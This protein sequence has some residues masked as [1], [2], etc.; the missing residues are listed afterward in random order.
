MYKLGRKNNGLEFVPV[1]K[2]ISEVNINFIRFSPIDEYKFVSCGRENIRFW[3]LKSSYLNGCPVVLNHHARQSN[4]TVLDYCFTAESSRQGKERRVVVGAQ[5]GMVYIVDHD[6]RKLQQVLRLHEQA[7]CSLKIGGGF[8]VT[9][10]ADQYI[11]VWP[12]DFGEFYVEAKHD[13][14]VVALDISKDGLSVGLGTTK[15]YLGILDLTRQDCKTVIRAH[16]AGVDGLGIDLPSE[17]L[18]SLG[19]DDT[20]RVWDTDICQQNYEFNYS[21]KDECVCIASLSSS[22]FIGGFASGI[23]RVFDISSVSVVE[24]RCYLKNSVVDLKVS[25]DKRF[26]IVGDSFGIYAIIDIKSGYQL[27]KYIY[28][29]LEAVSGMKVSIAISD[30]SNRIAIIGKNNTEIDLYDTKVFSRVFGFGLNKSKAHS[31][32][33]NKFNPNELIV[34]CVD[35]AVRFYDIGRSEGVRVKY[36]IRKS[37]GPFISS[38]ITITPY[39]YITGGA[40]GLLRVWTIQPGNPALIQI[41]SMEGHLREVIDFILDENSKALFSVGGDEGIFV[42]DIYE[43]FELDE[44]AERLLTSNGEYHGVSSYNSAEDFE[45]EKNEKQREKRILE[46][47]KDV[48]ELN[49]TEEKI[50]NTDKEEKEVV[51]VLKEGIENKKTED[52][53]VV[54]LTDDDPDT[55]RIEYKRIVDTEERKETKPYNYQPEFLRRK[56][57]LSFVHFLPDNDITPSFDFTS[58]NNQQKASLKF[59]NSI[60]TRSSNNFHFN[61]ETNQLFYFTENKLIIENL[62]ET[63]EQKIIHINERISCML[64]SKKLNFVILGCFNT[65]EDFQSPIYIIDLHTHS[66]KKRQLHRKGIQ[67]IALSPDGEYLL[68]IGTYNDKGLYIVRLSDLEIFYKETL[69]RTANDCKI[70]YNKFLQMYV[71]FVLATDNLTVITF[72]DKKTNI[73]QKFSLP[74]NLNKKMDFCLN[75]IEVKKIDKFG[76]FLFLGSNFGDFVVTRFSLSYEIVP[77][78][79]NVL[80]NSKIAE[81]EITSLTTKKKQNIISIGTSNGFLMNF[82]FI[83]ETL[84]EFNPATDIVTLNL[85]KPIRTVQHHDCLTKGLV[86]LADGS[87]NYFDFSAEKSSEF[88][89]LVNNQNPIVRMEVMNNEKNNLLI[90][91]HSNGDVNIYKANN[92]EFVYKVPIDFPVT[93]FCIM[94]KKQQIVFFGED[95]KISFYSPF[96]DLS[97]TCTYTP[98]NKDH[99]TNKDTTHSFSLV[100]SI[101]TSNK[102]FYILANKKGEVYIS[103]LSTEEK[104]VRLFKLVLPNFNGKVISLNYTTA[105]YLAVADN[106]GRVFIFR[107]KNPL[108]TKLSEIE[109]DFSN[110]FTVETENRYDYNWVKLASSELEKHKNYL[111]VIANKMNHL[112]IYNCVTRDVG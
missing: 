45:W 58:L 92:L 19:K 98:I 50:D 15:G 111:Y 21:S 18:I 81:G 43:L 79:F 63:R 105:G 71:C 1:S 110:T 91:Q 74:F 104:G 22:K 65:T 72:N 70:V 32:V 9:G 84:K 28:G 107:N 30:D 94:N 108:T 60:E 47:I 95:N 49:E 80:I 101:K 52:D 26:I 66:M 75:C 3:R 62:D 48:L 85:N 103:D 16:F 54:C 87:I 90:C 67:K 53:S 7:I 76:Y 14:S 73:I 61:K 23:V 36:M 20:I 13:G 37:H 82:K 57:E 5:T 42:W 2:H 106:K 33:F 96:S 83:E 12:L 17:Q 93:S 68:T 89:S 78:S 97:R 4:F 51:V 56:N 99:T 40:D 59:I 112:L 27:V 25:K 35:G 10:S 100:E 44:Q 39:M 41:C 38:I 86:L 24:E 11:R 64:F 77:D 34:L 109:F 102:E 31:V 88:L 55:E 6:T 29:D 46:E 8:C 69:Y